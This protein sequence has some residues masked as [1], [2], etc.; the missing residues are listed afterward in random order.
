MQTKPAYEWRPKFFSWTQGPCCQGQVWGKSALIL[1]FVSLTRSS[2]SWDPALSFPSQPPV[3]YYTLPPNPLLCSYYI[4]NKEN[5]LSS[6]RSCS[7]SWLR[8][9]LSCYP[10]GDPQTLFQ[11][12]NLCILIFQNNTYGQSLHNFFCLRA[13]ENS[14]VSFL[15]QLKLI[16]FRTET[17][18]AFNNDHF[19]CLPAISVLHF[20]IH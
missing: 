15:V 20:T 14:I 3:H 6:G 16:L 19:E 13:P 11:E 12:H 9:D 17:F 8:L 1:T 18:T 4:P 5:V 7:H 2:T 10:T